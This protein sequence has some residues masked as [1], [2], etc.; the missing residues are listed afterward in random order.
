MM[1]DGK[2]SPSRNGERGQ[3]TRQGK[4]EPAIFDLLRQD[5]EKAR[6]L[7]Q[8]IEKSNK[9][10]VEKRQELFTELEQQLLIHMEGEERFF[11]T[12]LEQHDAAR[13]QVLA[14]YEAHL[15]ARTVIGAFISLAVD[16]ERWSPKLKVLRE[17]IL[18][19]MD[20]E[21]HVLFKM[22][23]K[24]LGSDQLEAIADKVSELK[25]QARGTEGDAPS[26]KGQKG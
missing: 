13:E 26:S 3:G 17:L 9:K 18:R 11:Y 10:E 21:E 15:V 25:R 22:A 5:H 19:H 2:Q 24:L 14:S 4:A 8:K 16:D 12:A 20:E 6:E 7:F 1:T 23:G